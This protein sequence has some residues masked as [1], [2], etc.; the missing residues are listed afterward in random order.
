[1]R[2]HGPRPQKRPNQVFVANHTTVFDI[3]I[4][5]QNFCFSVVGQKHP[6]IMGMKQQKERRKTKTKKKT[7]RKKEME[8]NRIYSSLFVLFVLNFVNRI[9]PRLCS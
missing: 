3:V 5:Q 9:F 6:G 8:K 7:K 2:Y 1:M 4:L